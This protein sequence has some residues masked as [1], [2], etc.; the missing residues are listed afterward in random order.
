[1]TSF[2]SSAVRVIQVSPSPLRFEISFQAVHVS[3]L[4]HSSERTI[5]TIIAAERWYWRPAAA[6]LEGQQRRDRLGKGNGLRSTDSATRQSGSRRRTACAGT[7]GCSKHVSHAVARSEYDADE[8]RHST[9]W[10]RQRHNDDR[11]SD[12]KDLKGPFSQKSA[13]LRLSPAVR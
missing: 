13:W 6:E 3:R 11:Q 5:R 1:M 8:S 9:L 12:R 10:E 2:A 4:D 7:E